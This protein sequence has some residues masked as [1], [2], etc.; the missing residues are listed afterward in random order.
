[1]LEKNQ[2]VLVIDDLSN[3]AVT[4]DFYPDTNFQVIHG[5]ICKK[6]TRDSALSFLAGIETI[7]IW[8]L[9]A[10]SDI[11]KSA[12]NPEIEIEKTLN[13]TLGAIELSKSFK[14][15]KFIFSSSS[16]VY[17]FHANLELD[18]SESELSPISPYGV[19]KLASEHF[20]KISLGYEI[21]S[22][23]IFRFPNVVGSP[24]THGFLFDWK[25]RIIQDNSTL[26]VLGDGNQKKQYLHVDNL[27]EMMFFVLGSTS[28]LEIFNLA[29]SDAGIST[30]EIVEIFKNVNDLKCRIDFGLSQEGW[31][32]DI[33][34]Y[35]LS[36]NKLKKVG[37]IKECN[38]LNEVKRSIKENKI[39]LDLI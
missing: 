2:K 3:N 1:M 24:L 9:A 29:P 18:E 30:K 21:S 37:W 27:I 13:S 19:A 28:H 5:D 33:P 26:K 32:G 39:Y 38:S 14:K 35:K 4:G 22:L 15:V 7:T 23:F 31:R 11:R 16:A 20:L 34:Q 12:E 8:H 6:A 36:I 17:G 10:N 25:N